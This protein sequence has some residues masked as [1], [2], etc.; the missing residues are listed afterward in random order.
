MLYNDVLTWLFQ[1]NCA[2]PH[3]KR[4]EFQW[5]VEIL[6]L[7]RFFSEKKKK[8]VSTLDFQKKMHTCTKDP[9]DFLSTA[10]L[11]WILEKTNEITSGIPECLCF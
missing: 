8:N 7:C 10:S 6:D 11:V 9:D 4:L 5:K 1:I 3:K 2:L